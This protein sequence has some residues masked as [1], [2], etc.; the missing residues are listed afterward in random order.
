MPF[1]ANPTPGT[2]YRARHLPPGA[3]V[4]MFTDAEYVR[5]SRIDSLMRWEQPIPGSGE[6]MVDYVGQLPA[7]ERMTA[8]EKREVAACRA[9]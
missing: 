7:G 8:R 1:I 5:C 4:T 6:W 2:R 3:V 9:A